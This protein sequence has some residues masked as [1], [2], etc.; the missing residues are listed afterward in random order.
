[1]KQKICV[2][3]DVPNWAFDNLA[4]K[5]KKELSNK[6]D[7]VIDYFD[8]RAESD[9]FYEFIEKHNNCDLVHFLNR[10]ML[11][12]MGEKTFKE[13]VIKSGKIYENYIEWAVTQTIRGSQANSI[14][15]SGNM[16]NSEPTP[17]YEY[18]LYKIYIKNI[19]TE[20][21]SIYPMTW[22][23]YADGVGTGMTFAVLPDSH[24]ELESIDIRSGASVSGWI[25]CEVPIGSNVRIYYEPLFTYGYNQEV[26]FVT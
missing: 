16:F 17:G 26:Y 18:F 9:F 14:V 12:L 10:R 8:R 1:M 19:G 6:Y 2:V 20:V 15:A 11:L 21:Y 23:A 5:I 24:K 25:V 3:A 4:Q 7:I 13:K 22:A